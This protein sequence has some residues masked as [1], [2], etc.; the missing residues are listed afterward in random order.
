MI[1]FY[2]IQAQMIILMILHDIDLFFF[3]DFPLNLVTSLSLSWHYPNI[4]HSWRILPY[5][6]VVCEHNT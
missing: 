1:S 2:F 5:N 6:I 3:A 4:F